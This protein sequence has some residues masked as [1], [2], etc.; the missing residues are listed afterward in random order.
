MDFFVPKKSCPP[1]LNPVSAP[2]KKW[3][4]TEGGENQE[5]YICW[6][7]QGMWKELE[8]RGLQLSEQGT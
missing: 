5:I 6:G 7:E 8:V 2:E 3:K 1:H 4:Q